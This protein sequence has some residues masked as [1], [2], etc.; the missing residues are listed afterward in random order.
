MLIPDYN[1]HLC[2]VCGHKIGLHTDSPFNH[3]PLI[4]VGTGEYPKECGRSHHALVIEKLYIWLEDALNKRNIAV[5]AIKKSYM[6]GEDFGVQSFATILKELYDAL[7]KL[8]E[9]KEEK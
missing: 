6:M 8:G 5:E 3:N 7:D 4:E 2:P 9:L 1:E